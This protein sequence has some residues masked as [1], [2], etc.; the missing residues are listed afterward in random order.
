MR[1]T[2]HETI[3][4]IANAWSKRGTCA[5]RQVGAV[6]IDAKENVIASGYNGQ[7]RSY[8]HCTPENPCPAFTNADLSCVAIHAEINALMRCADIDKAYAIYVTT[9]PCEK[10][11]LA[12]KNT[13]IVFVLYPD[14]YNGFIM[15]RITRE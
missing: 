4:E 15:R 7:P 9:E 10:C 3:F 11:M 6:I 1:P 13:N 2:I 8:T 14:K 12:I 5:K